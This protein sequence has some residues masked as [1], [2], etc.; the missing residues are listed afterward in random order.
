M[1][2]QLKHK[3]IT[4][5]E[6]K[7]DNA[8]F[9]AT[10]EL[11]ELRDRTRL[12]QLALEDARKLQAKELKEHE[13]TLKGISNEISLQRSV[14]KALKADIKENK[15]LLTEQEK[16]IDE[17][18]A[19]GNAHI[20]DLQHEAMNSE[21]IKN[22]LDFEV[23]H[24][25]TEKEQ[26]VKV[27]TDLKSQMTLLDDRYKKQNELYQKTLSELKERILS[28]NVELKTIQ[29]QSKDILFKLMDKEKALKDK[30]LALSKV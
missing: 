9:K 7:E 30:E 2:T 19:N 4:I 11:Q 29:A 14:L 16:Q 24:L 17:A 10:R 3:P 21:E 27:T 25:S 23:A 18:V 15:R 13:D 20:I 22:R 5:E 26:L 12:N 8:V 28:A 1:S 6:I